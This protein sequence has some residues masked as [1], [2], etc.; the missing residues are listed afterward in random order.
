MSIEKFEFKWEPKTFDEMI[1]SPDIKEQLRKAIDEKPNML[2]V[3][4]PGTGKGTFTNVFLK[5][6]GIGEKRNYIKIN[7]SDETGIENIR[8]RVKSF[9]MG[10]S[11]E[12]LKIVYLNECDY[13]SINAQAMLR[14]LM[15]TVHKTTRFIMCCNYVHKIIPELLSRC[16]VYHLNN[17]PAPDVV[18]RCWYILDQEGIKY[19]KKNVVNM[20]KSI[21]QSAPDIR[22]V[23]IT[24]KK[25]IINGE[26]SDN[27]KISSYDEVYDEILTAM[28]S[29]DPE[30]VRK[31]LKSN[32]IDYTSLYKFLYDKLMTEEQ[33][34][35]KDAEAILLIGEHCYRDSVIAIKE[36][37][38][39]HMYFSMLSNEVV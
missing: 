30:Q 19:D 4:P 3:G 26:L 14:D 21:W 31:L 20:V 33:L 35:S 2:L 9:S 15:E 8:D 27:I 7:C 25:N 16:E 11:F 17:P 28:K 10:V 22:K 36:I 39:M 32:T 23:L 24:L 18:K 38:F 6:T 29:C 1:L 5:E 13:L 34:F 12:G 37:N